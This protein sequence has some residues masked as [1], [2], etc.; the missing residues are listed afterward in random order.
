MTALTYNHAEAMASYFATLPKLWVPFSDCVPFAH[1]LVD[2][3]NDPSKLDRQAVIRPI[4]NNG[5]KDHTYTHWRPISFAA[6]YEKGWFNT[7]NDID[8]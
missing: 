7:E 6:D 5:G 8:A 4:A 1:W 2:V 3:T